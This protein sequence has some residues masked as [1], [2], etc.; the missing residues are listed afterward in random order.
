[1]T[2]THPC[3]FCKTPVECDGEYE[4]NYNGEPEVICVHFHLAGGSIAFVLCPD[5]AEDSDE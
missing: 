3:R 2:H 4:R 5:C 1:M